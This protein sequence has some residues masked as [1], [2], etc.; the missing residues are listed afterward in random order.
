VVQNISVD[1][2]WNANGRALV[3]RVMAFLA[4]MAAAGG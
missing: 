2:E 4:G 1:G 3:D